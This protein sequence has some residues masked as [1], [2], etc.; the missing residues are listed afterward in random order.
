MSY[1]LAYSGRPVG[2]GYMLTRRLII[3]TVVCQE[4]KR[5]HLSTRKPYRAG[6]KVSEVDPNGA[7]NL[8][9]SGALFKGTL[10]GLLG[11][12]SSALGPA[13]SGLP[14]DR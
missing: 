3:R 14:V 13:L 1:L 4:P 6:S 11:P 12:A 2:N 7:L 5:V 9:R 10:G 8:G